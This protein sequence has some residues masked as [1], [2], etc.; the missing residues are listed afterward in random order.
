[1]QEDPLT[2]RRTFV[3]RN[4]LGLHARALEKLL[5]RVKSY[6]SA[7]WIEKEGQRVH[8]KTSG[9][10]NPRMSIIGLL[11]L[12]AGLGSVIEAEATGPDAEE[13]LGAIGALIDDKFGESE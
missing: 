12:G 8:A 9:I 4:K 13:L 6:E 7:L 10:D 1:M 5:D 11:V 3:I 2:A